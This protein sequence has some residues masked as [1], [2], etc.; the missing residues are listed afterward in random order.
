VD[1]HLEELARLTD[2]AGGEAVG[3]LVQRI[4]RP[5]PRF[6]LGKVRT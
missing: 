6:F 2:T 1:E 5:H 3:T 4:D